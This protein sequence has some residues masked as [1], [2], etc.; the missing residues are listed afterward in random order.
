VYKIGKDD[1]DK[2]D[3]CKKDVLDIAIRTKKV[4]CVNNET[5]P[6]FIISD[7]KSGLITAFP[8]A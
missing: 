2:Y 3:R 5:L 6:V 7:S 1:L 4:S 8:G